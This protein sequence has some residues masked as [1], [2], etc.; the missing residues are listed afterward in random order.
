MSAPCQTEPTV[1]K[2]KSPLPTTSPSGGLQASHSHHIPRPQRWGFQWDP[3]PTPAN[4]CLGLGHILGPGRRRRAEG[5][6]QQWARNGIW[7]QRTA[8]GSRTHSCRRE[9]CRIVR[10]QAFSL[11][12]VTPSCVCCLSMPLPSC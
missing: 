8:L 3:R 2:A 11:L 12:Q 10:R 6:S 1:N 4:H 5:K 7:P 9:G